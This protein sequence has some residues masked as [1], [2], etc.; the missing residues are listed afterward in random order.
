MLGR[1]LGWIGAV[2]LVVMISGVAYQAAAEEPPGQAAKDP[3]LAYDAALTATERAANLAAYETHV[4]GMRHFMLHEHLG[5]WVVIAGAK[6]FPVNE[7][8][9]AVAPAP[10]M[11][12]AV[13]AARTAVPKARHRFVF[14]IGEEGD[15][16]QSLG[17]V[18]LPHVF[19]VWFMAALEPHVE[20][21][22]FGGGRPITYRKGDVRKAITVKG[23][24]SRTYVR[25]EVGAP[26]SKGRAEA[27]YCLSTGF[28]GYTTVPHKTAVAA[29]LHLWEI[30]G[31][32]TVSGVFQKGECR[33]ARMRIKFPETDI[34]LLL[35]VAVWSERR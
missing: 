6:A 1:A 11:E 16:T 14:R 22:V 24:D 27:L 10:T 12:A 25:P 23:P 4:M 21:L 9:T 5:H 26:G 35:P 8:G 17:G 2:A 28:A 32:I 30:P 20:M 19:G 18:E 34:D 3:V 13:A 31:H 15:L 7:H 29:S 33:R